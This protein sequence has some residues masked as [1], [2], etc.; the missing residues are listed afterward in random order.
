MLNRLLLFIVVVLPLCVRTQTIDNLV[1]EGAGIRGIAY[2]GALMELEEQGYLSSV[3]RV[4]GTSS[5]AITASLLSVGYTPQEI[6]DI[7]GETNFGKFNDGGGLFIGG[8]HRLKKKLGYYKGRKFLD[9]L[10][11]LIEA[12]TGNKNFTFADLEQK[13]TA[14]RFNNPFKHLVISATSLNHQEALFFSY[15]T[16]PQMRIVDAVRASMAVPYY[17][18]PLIIDSL[19]KSVSFKEMK[20][21]DHICVDGGFVTN[22]PIY[23]FDYAPYCTGVETPIAGTRNCSGSTFG[24]RIDNQDQIDADQNGHRELVDVPIADIKDYSI[25]FY[26]LVKESMNRYMLTE[27][28]WLRTISISDCA[29]GPKVKKLSIAEKQL[30]IDAGRKAVREKL[31]S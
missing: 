4:A 31:A 24:L 3:Q 28:D 2:C 25:A 10:E 29:I 18:E 30:L 7:I 1:F 12:K 21:S 26:Y 5:G 13:V 9:W 22:F 6:Y 27:D 14:N 19:G 11:K 8:I 16:Y 20:P 15:Y 23:I 17:F